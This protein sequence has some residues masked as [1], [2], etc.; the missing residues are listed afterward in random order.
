[1]KV[2][3]ILIL[4]RRFRADRRGNIAMIAALS[5]LGLVGSAGLGIDY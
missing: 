3:A 5:I 1:M 4:W 2:N